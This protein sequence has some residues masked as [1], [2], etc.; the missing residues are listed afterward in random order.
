MAQVVSR[1]RDK[2]LICEDEMRD[3]ERRCFFEHCMLNAYLYLVLL[4]GTTGR[5]NGGLPVQ[6]LQSKYYATT[7]KYK[8]YSSTV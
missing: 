7:K 2:W 8:L 3:A 4:P 1:V 5:T 6:V